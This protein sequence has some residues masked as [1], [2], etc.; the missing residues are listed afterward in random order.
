MK[1]MEEEKENF[2]SIFFFVL[3]QKPNYKRMEKALQV[4]NKYTSSPLLLMVL[5]MEN[6][7][8]GAR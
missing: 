6:F 3:I 8:K 5:C 7:P 2:M 4:Q 1:N